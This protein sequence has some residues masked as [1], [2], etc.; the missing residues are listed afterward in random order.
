MI[1][2]CQH[3]AGPF[4]TQMATPSQATRPGTLPASAPATMPFEQAVRWMEDRD[5]VVATLIACVEAVPIDAEMVEDPRAIAAVLAMK[6]LRPPEAAPC[7]A[8]RIGVSTWLDV[9]SATNGVVRERQYG[10]YVTGAVPMALVAIGDAALEPVLAAYVRSAKRKDPLRYVSVIVKITGGNAD[11]ARQWLVDQRRKHATSK[12]ALDAIDEL[13][14][15]L[16][17]RK[18]QWDAMWREERRPEELRSD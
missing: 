15:T 17:L 13:I 5:R 18:A 9:Y 12:P 8:A 11:A 2:G 4:P 6:K 7:L 3:L 16:D 1:L 10:F 14:R